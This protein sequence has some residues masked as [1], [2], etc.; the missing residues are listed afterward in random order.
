V[1]VAVGDGSRV[2]DI[3]VQRGDV[4]VAVE[5]DGPSHYIR[6]LSGAAVRQGGATN[7]RNWV[8]QDCWGVPLVSVCVVDKS[9]SALQSKEMGKW[10]LE[11][12]GNTPGLLIEQPCRARRWGSGYWSS[13]GTLQA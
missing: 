1:Q 11:Q 9:P 3:L 7:L 5:V 12:L 8:L 10:L 4:A 2:V 13:S 6:T